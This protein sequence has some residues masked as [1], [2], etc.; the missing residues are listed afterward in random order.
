MKENLLQ[1][2]EVPAIKLIIKVLSNIKAS[3]IYSF[4]S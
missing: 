4:S 2:E 1:K 3:L